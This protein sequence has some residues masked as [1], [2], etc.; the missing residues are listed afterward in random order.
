MRR[1][2]IAPHPIILP[3]LLLL[4]AALLRL[5][6]A[7]TYVL[8][9]DEFSVQLEGIRIGVE[10]QRPLV[11]TEATFQGLTHHS[12][13]TSYLLA[14]PYVLFPDPGLARVFVA[15]CG[16]LTVALWYAVVRRYF[17]YRAAAFAGLFLA[18]SPLAVYWSR[19]VWN[20][21]LGLVF[22]PLW[23][24]TGL[25]AYHEGGR[26]AQVLHWLALSANIQSQAVLIYLLPISLVL[27]LW[28]LMLHEKRSR[29]LVA[30]GSGIAL[31][32]LSLLPWYRGLRQVAASSPA[33]SEMVD[34]AWLLTTLSISGL[35]RV[36]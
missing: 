26:R 19:F 12:P 21:N 6:F 29:T 36:P 15:L 23:F 3:L 1:L 31:F 20:P 16:I 27:F 17:D 10:G 14:I 7:D 24:I 4:L 13:F 2:N 5:P 18:I 28:H 30:T 34:A 35:G 11:G 8:W 33:A 25:R 9:A 22:V 32:A